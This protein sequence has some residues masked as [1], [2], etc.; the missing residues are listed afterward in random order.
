MKAG[1]TEQERVYRRVFRTL[2]GVALAVFLVPLGAWAAPLTFEGAQGSLGASATFDVSG[3][4][5][6]V[7]LRNTSANDVMVPADVLTGLFF[8]IAGSPGLTQQ[9][10]VL[11]PGAQVHFGSTDPGG[12]VG[13]EWAYRQG[14]A[15]APGS[16]SYGI[17]SS[18]LGLFGRG[19]LFLGSN[20]DGPRSPGGL[21]Y[22][23]LSAGDD[24]GTGNRPVTGKDPLIQHG[25]TFTLGGV[26]S[27][28]SPSD[29]SNVQFQYGTNLSEPNFGGNPNVD[30]PEPG[31]MLLLAAGAAVLVAKARRRS[32]R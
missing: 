3:S 22:G 30:V 6:V 18:G 20:L 21:E 14:L 11:A 32:R 12:A 9:T 5:L 2:I 19:D 28:F 7:T 8:D 4:N 24:V 31:T 15:G 1:T 23:I 25:V 10:A 26:P 27:N 29:V 13:G 16:T 17:S